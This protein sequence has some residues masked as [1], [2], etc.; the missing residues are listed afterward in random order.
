LPKKVV[1]SLAVF[2]ASLA[3][4]AIPAN[5]WIGSDTS[6]S[7]NTSDATGG[8]KTTEV[9]LVRR[10]LS[11]GALRCNVDLDNT[12]ELLDVVRRGTTRRTVRRAF[13]ITITQDKPGE[14]GVFTSTLHKPGYIV[15]LFHGDGDI[16][17]RRNVPVTRRLS[18]KSASERSWIAQIRDGELPTY[19]LLVY[20]REIPG[21]TRKLEYKLT[22]RD[23]K[24]DK[25]FRAPLIAET[26]LL[27]SKTYFDGRP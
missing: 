9:S 5:A 18:L 19:R 17:A 4:A 24:Q 25:R 3:G 13:S 7:P 27:S 15:D 16:P 8:D 2:V 20:C 21:W 23:D 10:T 11:R 6:T 14:I 22:F 1:T 26:K 12:Q